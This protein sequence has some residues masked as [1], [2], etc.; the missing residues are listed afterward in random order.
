M[1]DQ[2]PDFGIYL[3][4]IDVE[5]S[6]LLDRALQC[7]RLGFGSFWL[8]DHLSPPGF[9]GRGSL[10]G[11]TTATAL[12]ARTTRL[13]V[14][15]LVL[16]NSFRHPALL[17]KMAT[18]LDLISDGRLDLGIGTGSVGA[19]HDQAGLPFGSAR[20]R[21]E[22]L[23]EALE[24]ITRM[25]AAPVTSF[26]GDHYQVH[27][28]PNVPGPRQ[29]PRPPIHIGGAGPRFTLPLAARYADVWN[30]PTYA[31]D[32][33]AELTRALDIECE[34]IG[35]DPATLRRSVEAVLAIAEPAGVEDALTL[36]RRRFGSPG[37]GLEAGGFTGTPATV[38]DRI[39]EFGELGYSSFVFL[40]HDRAA[41]ESLEL[42]A[43]EVMPQFA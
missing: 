17:A 25:F 29:L 28:L 15:H 30:L 24:V 40:T 38:C 27:E 21:S 36:A 3:P 42:F 31:L 34:R 10:E 35:R 19:E 13:R 9:P 16:A 5:F 33:A 20:I 6:W 4:Q 26:A 1:P 2:A 41:T 7:E 11:W 12:L 32:R 39:G 22:Q 37:F 43:A 23:G 8:F 14:G 18:T